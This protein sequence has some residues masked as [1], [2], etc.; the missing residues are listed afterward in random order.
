MGFQKGHPRS[1]KILK[2]ESHPN[3]VGDKIKY[4]SL[5]NWVRYHLGKAVECVYCGSSRNVEW[6]SI[7]HKAKRRL[8]DYIPLC[9]RCHG[10]YDRG[11][12]TNKLYKNNKSGYAG[13]DFLKKSRK[14]RARAFWGKNKQ[15]HIGLFNTK[16]EAIL[17]RKEYAHKL[18]QNELPSNSFIV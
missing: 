11:S 3:W 2:G 1:N 15:I 5:H 7:S 18:S 16:R 10:I 12:R 13:V 8:S 9:K 17:A 14:W 6:A 4:I